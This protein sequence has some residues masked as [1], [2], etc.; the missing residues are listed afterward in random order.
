MDRREVG[1]MTAAAEAIE[2]AGPIQTVQTGR[3]RER[4]APEY[5]YLLVART[6]RR[7]Q[8]LAKLAANHRA[9]H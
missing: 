6:D 1:L 2:N 3:H 8:L 4:Q 7:L 5:P 9:K